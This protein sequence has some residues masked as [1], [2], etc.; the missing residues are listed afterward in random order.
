MKFRRVLIPCAFT[1]VIAIAFCE[2]QDIPDPGL[3]SALA[4]G[5][6][7]KYDLALK[8]ARDEYDAKTLKARRTAVQELEIAIKDITQA[9]NLDEAN[10]INALIKD[11]D[12]ADTG[13]SSTAPLKGKWEV[14]FNT[15]ARHTYTMRDGMIVEQRGN[16][17]PST[18]KLKR[19]GNDVIAE[20]G[21]D[22]ERF[23]VMGNRLV[24]EVF[25]PRS[26]YPNQYAEYVA[27][28][29]R[30]VDGSGRSTR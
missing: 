30:V 8:E 5:A 21:D 13:E 15:G 20:S 11:L 17:K 26:R 12:A 1:I 27:V 10:R 19:N 29:K 28:G 9:G 4:R 7:R 16:E 24:V 18:L 2:A 14:T 3:T 22:I 6:M 23:T 25:R